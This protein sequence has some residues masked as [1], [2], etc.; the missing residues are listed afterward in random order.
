MPTPECGSAS[1]PGRSPRAVRKRLARRILPTLLVLAALL[2]A[3]EGVCRLLGY[4]GDS[5]AARRPRLAAEW[6]PTKNGNLQPSDVTPGM[7]KRVWWRCSADPDHE[8]QT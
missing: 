5:L 2:L 4:P 1:E 7:G 8:W 3:A 6:H